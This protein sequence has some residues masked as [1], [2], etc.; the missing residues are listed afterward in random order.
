MALSVHAEQVLHR[1]TLHL[2]V[3]STSKWNI[4]KIVYKVIEH[5]TQKQNSKPAALHAHSQR[6]A[7]VKKIQLHNHRSVSNREK[8]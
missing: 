4:Y 6:K 1:Q 2:K 8:T 3:V 7:Q 5:Y